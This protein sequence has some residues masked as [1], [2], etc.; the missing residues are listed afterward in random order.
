MTVKGRVL[1]KFPA[2]VFATDGINITI[3]NGVYTFSLDA[4]LSALAG[5]EGEG[6]VRR[7]GDGLLTAGGDL[8]LSEIGTRTAF[9][10]IGNP[11]AV[12][13]HP[14][15]ITVGANLSFSGSTLSALAAWT[16]TRLAKTANYTVVNG[17]K[18]KT[19]A[20]GGNAF[21]TLTIGAA[22]GFDADFAIVVENEDSD[23]QRGKRISPN[24][25]TSFI[26]YPKQCVRIF[27]QNNVWIIDPPQQLW[28]PTTLPT[29][30]VDG[31]NGLSTN[32]GLATGAGGAV[33]TIQQGVD[34]V[35]KYIDVALTGNI[36]IQLADGT[37]TAGA[38]ITGPPRGSTTWCTIQGNE[39]TPG[40]VI[41]SISSGACFNVLDY[42][43]VT[44]RAMRLQASSGNVIGILAKAFAL[45]DI[46]NI[47]FGSVGATG[48]HVQ[49]TQNS[50]CSA[51]GNYA[52][53]GNAFYH[54]SINDGS[55]FDFGGA[56]VT[57]GSARAFTTFAI[58]TGNSNITHSSAS[59]S[60][61]GVAGTTG[62]R[63]QSIDAKVTS[64]LTFPGNAA[65]TSVVLPPGPGTAAA[66]L[67]SQ[68]I[69]TNSGWY[70]AGADN[71]AV[72]AGGGK[73]QGWTT[74]GSDITGLLD[75]SAASSGQIKFPA[76]QNA[77]SNVNTLDDYEEGTWTPV[78]TFATPGNLSVAY[79]AQVGS[80]TKNGNNVRISFHIVTSSFTHTTA[81]GQCLIT[82]LPFAAA[83]VA[84]N[85]HE[86]GGLWSGITKANYT[87]IAGSI[88]GSTSQVGLMASGSAQAFTTVVAADMP[89]GGA[90]TLKMTA[91]YQSA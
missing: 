74:T 75:L 22:S 86:C 10:L 5:M 6:L 17:D 54:V 59:F 16:N 28:R 36:P 91:I 89:T 38:T 61:A 58:G 78:L 73:V 31:T 27:N 56:T 33:A 65:G 62:V 23:T 57:I 45:I 72:S 9:T 83:N 80:Y 48:I 49:I 66:P 30:Y 42:A 12:V 63:F 46:A 32:D 29:I 44:I 3:A 11:T 34:I 39:S 71:P 76:T 67:Y 69:D 7:A 40:N 4:D 60:G 82:G 85:D 77:S 51:V 19:L 24:G 88:L 35:L 26:L 20:L 90:V 2:Q 55:V 14:I 84:N 18:G 81:S 68:G 43:G 21:F 8:A 50:V 41:V 52:I 87:D 37:Y 47:E 15:E 53:T 70:F 1:V 79:T 25:I 13:A 64:S